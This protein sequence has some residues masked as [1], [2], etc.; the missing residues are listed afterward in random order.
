VGTGL[1]KVLTGS[2]EAAG[3]LSANKVPLLM[4]ATPMLMGQD[5]QPGEP[6]VKPTPFYNTKFNRRINPNYGKP[7]ES[8]YVDS[9][10]PGS[11]SKDY[12]YGSNLMPAPGMGQLASDST[13]GTFDNPFEGSAPIGMK[14]GGA[15]HFDAGG[16]TGSGLASM[17]GYYQNLMTPRAPAQPSGND[18]HSAYLSSLAGTPFNPNFTPAPTSLDTPPPASTTPAIDT[19]ANVIHLPIWVD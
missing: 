19:T 7:G 5:T 2:P 15:V 10:G 13:L 6:L 3:F 11:F 4:S 9:Y 18:A 16:T 1:G 8:M 14:S 12:L 17:R